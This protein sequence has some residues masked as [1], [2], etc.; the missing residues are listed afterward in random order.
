MSGIYIHI[1]FCRKACHYCNF[2]FSTSLKY[3]GA[4]L[5]AIHKEIEMRAD[6]LEDNSIKTIYFGGGTP[7]VL[8]AQ[9]IEGIISSIDKYYNIT[10]LQEC[11]LE[12]N[13]D[14][15]TLSY[16]K[17]LKS[18]GIDRLSIGVQSFDPQDLIWM[19][20][21]HNAQQA[22]DSI[23]F[24]YQ[25]GIDNFSIDLIFG[26]PT[27]TDEIWESNMKIAADYSIRHLSCY[28]LTVEEKTALEHLIK[29]KKTPAPKDDAQAHQFKMT[30]EALTAFGYEHYEISNYSM[31]GY[32]SKHNSS[33][34]NQV[35]F[36][37]IGPS[38][39]SYNGRERQWNI[40]HNQKYIEALQNGNLNYESETLSK[41]D[42]YNEY[43]M[44]ALRTMRGVSLDAIK[45]MG[46]EYASHF[47]ERVETFLA[48]DKIII[49]NDHYILSNDAKVISDHVIAE[50]FI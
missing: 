45:K 4:M 46:E 10:E 8:S 25:A 40:A 29:S 9:E 22:R 21:S 50:L 7:S 31:P 35:P 12:A 5:T 47:L 32:Q 44:T 11:T 37:G 36:I 19:N 3:K 26:S 48:T 15:L 27:T 33:Y 6:Y 24:A 14:D 43:I 42:R 20:R 23:E 13:P 39:H 49:R 38:A 30:Q 1:P 28:A 2:H 17:D 16:V 18:V 34:W 41:E